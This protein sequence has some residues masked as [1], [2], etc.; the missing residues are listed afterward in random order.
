MLVGARMEN[1]SD[2]E[3]RSALSRYLD[4]VPPVT[5]K[6]LAYISVKIRINSSNFDR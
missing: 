4:V 2:D 1:I 3:L 6:P 5:G